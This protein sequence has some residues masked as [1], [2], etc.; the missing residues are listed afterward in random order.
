MLEVG[1]RKRKEANNVIYH[2]GHSTSIVPLNNSSHPENPPS[3]SSLY[4]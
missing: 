2:A 1:K 3:F 4:K